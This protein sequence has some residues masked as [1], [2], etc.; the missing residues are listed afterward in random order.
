M[1]MDTFVIFYKSIS[2]HLLP[3]LFAN[4]RQCPPLQGSLAYPS[5]FF[6]TK[7]ICIEDNLDLLFW[8]CKN[9]TFPDCIYY[10]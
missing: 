5:H 2:Y 9:E 3:K 4:A 7:L 1:Q 8:C 6:L 10:F